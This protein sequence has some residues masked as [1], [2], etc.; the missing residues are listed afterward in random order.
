M[1][2]WEPEPVLVAAAPDAESATYQV[3][4][5]P[6]STQV[7]ARTHASTGE[8]KGVWLSNYRGAGAP[9]I[10]PIIMFHIVHWIQHIA[11][12]AQSKTQHN[13]VR[14]SAPS[15]LIC[16]SPAIGGEAHLQ[17][18]RHLHQS[19]T[20]RR[21]GSCACA[22]SAASGAGRV[23]RSGV[24]PPCGCEAFEWCI[25]KHFPPPPAENAR[26]CARLGTRG[27]GAARPVRRREAPSEEKSGG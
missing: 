2:L 3:Q 10:I 27:L 26:N 9:A 11:W 18:Q 20:S 12:A 5:M 23:A 4:H 1:A 17:P 24:S 7:S 15:T 21:I 19:A 8:A 22:R 6:A 16:G 25:L 14:V 13:S